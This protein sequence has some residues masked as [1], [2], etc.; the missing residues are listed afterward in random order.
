MKTRLVLLAAVLLL[1]LWGEGATRFYHYYN[2]GLRFMEQK[3]WIRAI[4]EFKSAASL[5]FDD[6]G[7]KRIYGT[8]FIEYFPHRE[9]GIAHY[10]LGEFEMARK[11]LELSLAYEEDDRTVEY[12][13]RVKKG[14]PPSA[15]VE[16]P[17]KVASEPREEETEVESPPTRA[18]P[19]PEIPS[20]SITL[21]VGALT[22]DPARV[23]QVGSRLALAVIPFVG[24]GE[25]K[26]LAD[27]ITE[28]V[29]S[30]LVALR[31]F[32]VIE[33]TA[34]DK[35]LEEQSL[36]VSGLVDEK[37][38]TN[39]GKLAG[40]DAIVLGSLSLGR[41]R[42]RVSA[43]VIDTETGE[44]ILAKAEVT[45]GKELENAEVAAQKVAILIYNEL[46]IVEGYIVS[47][48]PSGFYIDIGSEKGIRKGSKCVAFREGE[49][50]KHPVTGEILGSRVTKLG[51]LVVVSVHEKMAVVKVT[52]KEDEITVGDKVVVK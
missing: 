30:Q 52:E 47:Q 20:H 4:G 41:D 5:E 11:E 7:R 18:E 25:A 34:L 28:E 3:D 9:M 1:P 19:K 21:P 16:V 51:E 45:D 50:I 14:I 2:E 46:P 22:Y 39:L 35:V 27:A 12:L 40:A 6:A 15:S 29:I 42:T 13:R 31:R 32:K 33:R 17:V 23:T 37:T 44:T 43:R 8:R 49:K 48:E 38:A 36:A 10:Q 24:K 26:D